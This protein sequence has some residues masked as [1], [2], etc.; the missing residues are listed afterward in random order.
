MHK[1]I[2]GEMK[3]QRDEQRQRGNE[4]QRKGGGEV[5]KEGERQADL[6]K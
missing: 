4:E 2:T 5:R 1:D 6:N 3:G